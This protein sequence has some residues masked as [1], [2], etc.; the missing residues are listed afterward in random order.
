MGTNNS[1]LDVYN[2]SKARLQAQANVEAEHKLRR[3]EMEQAF[4]IETENTKLSRDI[5]VAAQAHQAA[6][7]RV[8]EAELKQSQARA[9]QQ[10][11]AGLVDSSIGHPALNASKDLFEEVPG[12]ARGDALNAAGRV[13]IDTPWG[14][15]PNTTNLGEAI[16]GQQRARAEEQRTQDIANQNTF[17]AATE[18]AR[19]QEPFKDRAAENLAE[20]QQAAIVTRGDEARK[21]VRERLTAQ[22]KADFL[23]SEITPGEQTLYESFRTGDAEPSRGAQGIIERE[24]F[25]IA[26]PG[27]VPMPRLVKKQL[28][29]IDKQLFPVQQMEEILHKYKNM[30]PNNQP[31]AAIRGWA[32]KAAD[33]VGFSE[34]IKELKSLKAISPQVAKGL[35][36]DRLTELDIQRTIGA[37]IDEGITM[38]QALENI[39][40]FKQ[41]AI[42]ATKS[43]R[44]AVPEFQVYGQYSNIESIAKS[45][46][47]ATEEQFPNEEQVPDEELPTF[48]PEVEAGLNAIIKE[49]GLDPFNAGVLRRWYAARKGQN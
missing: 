43:S 32:S 45:L 5:Q 12:F 38:N 37:M 28:I 42:D 36:E 17:D 30:F 40:R 14:T 8:A 21:T 24:R 48:S 35:G 7:T 18:T 41:R 22:G 46:R 9:L 2:Q 15:I 6:Q 3:E 13:E 44:G 39:V 29:A 20:A 10:H 49:Q 27:Q 19:A 11:R 23:K 16:R 33:L 26:F 4:K 31:L 34:F 25:A 1:L 47:R